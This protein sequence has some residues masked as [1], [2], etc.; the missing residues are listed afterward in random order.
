LCSVEGA[1]ARVVFNRPAL[2]NAVTTEMFVELH[3]FVRFIERDD[4]V[5]C[6]VISGAGGHFCAGGDVKSMEDLLHK[7]PQERTRDFESNG[8]LINPLCL[9][10][11][12]I[13]QPVIVSARGAVAG[14]GF[15]LLLAAD[16]AIASENAK[17]LL[18]QV[19]IGLTSDLGATYY[20]PR[21]VGMKR[22][23]QIAM[24]GDVILARQAQEWGLIN[25]VVPDDCLD[26]ETEKLIARF[27]SGP[28]KAVAGIKA[29]L[30]S[31]LTSSLGNQL[32]SE[33]RAVSDCAGSKDFAEGVRAFHERR[34]AKFAGE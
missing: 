19:K 15:S 23:K 31:A 10:L 28:A 33:G 21:A 30:N 8:M 12:N 24:L 32:E 34:Q 27:T 18:A 29:L 11:E 17:L 3:E 9:A 13:P 5:R 7:T 4:A 14:G 2:R 26:A 20:L 6:L 16:I 25:F 1:V 22:A